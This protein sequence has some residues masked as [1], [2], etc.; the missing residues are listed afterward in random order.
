MKAGG[1]PG[2]EVSTLKLMGSETARRMRDTGLEAMGAHGM[3][4]HDDAPTEGRFPAYAMFTPALSIAGGSD[5]IQRN[6]AGERVLGLPREP[7]E[8]ERSGYFRRARAL[9]LDALPFPGAQETTASRLWRRYG[10][11]AVD[12]LDAIASDPRQS[13]ILIEGTEYL[14]CEIH[15]I[16]AHELVVKLDD[17]LRRRSKIAQVTR[18]EALRA[19]PG[20]RE[21]CEILFGPLAQTRY[22]EYFQP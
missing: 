9:G 14:R 20:L 2:P 3:L 16:A 19:A 8:A 18:G 17:F 5:E 6:I 7:G 13:D 1:Q 22:E 4:D 11:H 12:L 15:H 10:S 21:A